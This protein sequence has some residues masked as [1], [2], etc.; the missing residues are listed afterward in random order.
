MQGGDIAL[1]SQ[2]D[3]ALNAHEG[4]RAR[5]NESLTESYQR[6]N[7]FV[8][9]LRRL[10]VEKTKYEINVKFLKNLTQEWQ[11]MAINIQLSR[12]LGAMGLHDLFSMM[13]Q[14]EEYI[15]GGRSKKGIDPLALVV[16]PFGGPNSAPIQ[17]SSFNNMPLSQHPEDFNH[18]FNQNFN[19]G[20]QHP[21]DPM[22]ITI[23]DEELV[24]MNESLALISHNVQRL[25]A[26][27]EFTCSRGSG[28]QAE[29][30]WVKEEGDINL[31]ADISSTSRGEED[32]SM[33]NSIGHMIRA[34]RSKEGSETILDNPDYNYRGN[35]RQYGHE[36][37]YNRQGYESGY[38]GECEGGRHDQ[39]S[40]FGYE[41]G[42]SDRWSEGRIERGKGNFNRS[43]HRGPDQHGNNFNK[44]S[45]REDQQVPA[46][47]GGQKSSHPQKS[48]NQNPTP[49]Q[50]PLPRSDGQGP[51]CFKCGKPG[52][53]A[54]ECTV[55][56]KDAAYFEKKAALLRNKEKGVALL[57]E[58]ENWVCEEESSDEEDQLVRGHCLMA[59]FEGPD[60]V[61]PSTHHDN[62]AF[63][64]SSIPDITDT[65]SLLEAKICDLERD[66]QSERTLVTKFRIN[67]AVY[68]SSL[69]DLTLNYNREVLESSVRDSN[70]SNKLLSLQ[71][72][73]EELNSNHGELSIKFQ[74]LSEERTKRFSKIQELEDNNFKREQSEQTLSILT[75]HANKNPF[76]KA[77]PGLGLA[78]N[79]VLE[80][81]PS[82]L[83]WPSKPK[84]AF[85]GDVTEEYVRQTITYTE[86]INGKTITRT[87][88]PSNSTTSSPPTSPAANRPIFIPARDPNNTDPSWEG[89]KARTPCVAM[90]PINYVDLKISYATREIELSEETLVIPPTDVSATKSPDLVKLEKEVFGLRLKAMDLDACQ[91]QILNLRVIVSEK[92]H[93]INTLEKDLLEANV[94]IIRLSSECEIANSS[95][96]IFKTKFADLQKRLIIQEV[97]FDLEKELFYEKEMMYRQTFVNQ[98]D[99]KAQAQADLDPNVEYEVKVFLDN[100]DD[101]SGFVPKKKKPV[102]SKPEKSSESQA[103]GSEKITPRASAAAP[104]CLFPEFEPSDRRD[105]WTVASR[106]IYLQSERWRSIS[107]VQKA[108]F[109]CST[110]CRILVLIWEF[111]DREPHALGELWGPTR[112]LTDGRK[113]IHMPLVLF[114]LRIRAKPRLD[115]GYRDSDGVDLRHYLIIFLKTMA[116]HKP[117]SNSHHAFNADG[118]RKYGGKNVKPPRKDHQE[119][120]N[121]FTAFP[122]SRI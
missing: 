83:I 66:L 117:S 23:S 90:P 44:K 41:Q 47:Q 95:F 104:F 53:Y 87:T 32:I 122:K 3:S 108:N 118:R 30:E 34:E 38:G 55:K 48:N 86:V 68:K 119:R 29:T 74:L 99:K 13:V 109:F 94:E 63:E 111:V 36:S 42:R 71:K 121:Q 100:D 89:I 106:H 112:V 10:G 60:G 115:S 113:G 46:D 80:K 22:I 61:G 27:R 8:N 91:H 19:Q 120:N 40:E 24:N 98:D 56:Y 84:P 69:E 20:M 65:V 96:T 57:V 79:H 101:P 70:L 81:A 43:D 85:V 39:G 18:E 59:D 76:Y 62:E 49:Q 28:F 6:L 7:S 52:H 102:V 64:V 31:R 73:H 105:F 78:E 25:N 116:L 114:R 4:S 5:E 21:D 92:D 51:T 26:N 67:S 16:V 33:E 50:A 35:S 72:S 54:M 97:Q 12:N 1:E 58:E 9:D 93:L 75:K 14:H 15:T 37:G 88:S 103:S 107:E 45:P 17:P 77:R 110:V 82:N 11:N 2:K